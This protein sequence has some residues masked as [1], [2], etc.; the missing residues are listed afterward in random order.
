MVT[1]EQLAVL[2]GRRV[3]YGI[4]QAAFAGRM[5]FPVATMISIEKD[6]RVTVTDETYSAMCELLETMIREAMEERRI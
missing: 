3:G 5:G 6:P 4:H 1:H 2:R